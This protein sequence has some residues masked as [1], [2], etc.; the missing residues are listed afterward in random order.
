LKQD[1]TDLSDPNNPDSPNSPNHPAILARN[2]IISSLKQQLT[3][4]NSNLDDPRDAM[5][6][7]QQAQEIA[8]LKTEIS[9]L[10]TKHR[11]ALS[12]GE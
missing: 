4:A 2:D 12:E 7:Q 10:K 1:L 6:I 9:E 8:V 11:L 3:Q 5:R